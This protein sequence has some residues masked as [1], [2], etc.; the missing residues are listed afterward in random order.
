[1]GGKFLELQVMNLMVLELDDKD[2]MVIS[3]FYYF[4]KKISFSK[5]PFRYSKPSS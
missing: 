4:V 1:M 5:P 3:S 2:R